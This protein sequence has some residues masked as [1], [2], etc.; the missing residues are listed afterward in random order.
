M[1]GQRI[2]W[3]DQSLK[4]MS[5]L[6]RRLRRRIIEAVEL[7]ADTGHG[8]VKRLQGYDPAQWRLRVGDGAFVSGWSRMPTAS[9][10]YACCAETKRPIGN[11]CI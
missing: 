9:R 8:D 11:N 6:D 3:T 4:D 10:S 7:L 1:S 2:Q 5:H